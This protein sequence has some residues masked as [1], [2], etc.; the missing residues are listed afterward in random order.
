M[1]YDAEGKMKNTA[2]SGTGQS[3]TWI[4]DTEEQRGAEA[5]PRR[6]VDAVCA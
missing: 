1:A 6:F 4:F 3:I 5:D 2:D